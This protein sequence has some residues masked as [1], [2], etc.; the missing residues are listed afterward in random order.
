MHQSTIHSMYQDE[1][2]I[3]WFGTKKGL[4]RYDGTQ[5]KPIQKLFQDIPDA[6]ELVRGITG[7][8]NGK[9]YLETRSG[10]IQYDIRK[11]IFSKIT[12]FSQCMYYTD[13]CLWIGHK[14]V[15]YQ[16]KNQ[17][18]QT[19][20]R[21]PKESSMIDCI[22]ET[23]QG[24][25]YV[26]TREDGVFLIRRNKGITRIMPDIKQIRQLYVDSEQKIWV[27]TRRDGVFLIERN[28]YIRNFSY[29]PDK[30]NCISSNIIRS[31]CEDEAGDVW[32][33][34]F[35]GLNK[36]NR[37]D[38]QFIKYEFI[39]ENIHALNDASIYCLMKDQQGTIWSGSFFGEINCFHPEHGTFAYYFAT[40]KDTSLSS[41][42]HA[43]FGKAVEDKQ[44]NL[45]IA[46][47]RGGLYFFNPQTKQLNK[48]PFADNIQTLFLDKQKDILWIGTLLGGLKQY[49]IK[50][51]ST[52]TYMREALQNNSIREIIPYND[53]LILAT[54]N[55]VSFFTP[56]TKETHPLNTDKIELKG[57][58]ITTIL[59]DSQKQLWIAV[60]GQLICYNLSNKQCRNIYIRKSENCIVNKIIENRN[61]DIIIG[62]SRHGVFKKEKGKNNFKSL[63]TDDSSVKDIIDITEDKHGGIIIISNDG[64]THVAQNHEITHIN[65][66]RF[67]PTFQLS[68]N[69]L[70]IDHEQNIYLGGINM[71]CSFPLEQIFN[72]PHF[73]QVGISDISVN[74]A[75]L[76]VNDLNGLLKESIFYTDRIE[77][78]YDQHT[79][80]IKVFTNSYTS[81]FN[82]CIKYKLEPFDKE[83]KQTNSLNEISYNNLSP[84]KY[85]LHI[86][87]DAALDN[88]E[89]PEKK[90]EIIIKPPF[91]QTSIAYI[92][93][94][95]LSIILLYEAY[96]VIMLRSSLKIE[97][98][99]KENMEKL[100]QSKLRFF[101]NISH[102]FKTPL[103][104]ISNQV[105]L[106][107]QTPNVPPKLQVK[108]QSIWKNIV[109]LNQL[110]IELMEFRKQ[111][112]GFT[113]L[114]VT[115]CNFVDHINE[116]VSS[117]KEYAQ[118][119]N[120]SLNFIAGQENITFYFDKR[121]I[122]KALFNLLSN[123]FKFTPE[124]GSI[125]VRISYEKEKVTLEVID[126]GVGIQTNELDN[127]FIRFYQTDNACFTNSVGTGIGLAYTKN[128]VEAHKGT[129]TVKSVKGKGS[130][131]TIQLP[132]DITYSPKEVQE[133]MP[134]IE[135]IE[136]DREQLISAFLEE[137]KNDFSGEQ[138]EDAES[139]KYRL[140]IVEDNAELCR[141][142]AEV[143]NP[144]Y[145][146]ETA[147]NGQ[148]GYEK[149]LS[150]LPDIIISDVI[151][152]EMTG[153]ELCRKLKNHLETSHIP[154]I[155][156][157]SQTSLEY[158]TEGLQTG[159][160]DYINKPFSIKHLIIRCNNLV[161]SRHMLQQKY[162]KDA[163]L[164]NELVATT[165]LDQAI[166]DKSVQLI[167][168]NLENPVFCVDYLAQEIGIGRTKYFAKIKAITGMTPNDFI[169][170]IKLKLAHQIM[171]KQPDIS[172]SELSMQ[173]GFNSTSYFI[174]RF[175]EFSGMTPNQYKQR[176]E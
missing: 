27:A 29:S 93:Y 31:I 101:T 65:K 63:L 43:V 159:A 22:I 69:C 56:S 77:L 121:L 138:Q 132:T 155:L 118:S 136:A 17:R 111:E 135:N 160:D 128:I 6:E 117:F 147:E 13:S 46:A 32:I 38:N 81:S 1:F 125:L 79:I 85:I 153:T 12:P 100:N 98:E 4:V 21:L 67:L 66:S 172:V 39:S 51:R 96:Q 11:E 23:A 34:T 130:C 52:T 47:E 97:K 120:V 110:I 84:N 113:T 114:K 88:G 83:W 142:L 78:P 168:E 148:C 26:G 104:L 143:F 140:L 119:R 107:L 2:G 15:V 106:L 167:E 8:K 72:K 156:L 141:L 62:T 80:G 64:F 139:K 149:A 49:N 123:A 174:K 76:E 91:Y 68:S 175:K 57:K 127:I 71:F 18:M 173:L 24:N 170:N 20:Y 48:L 145:W 165:P 19:Y 45:W 35:N 3:M 102:E 16:W 73:Y 87:G 171:D 109:R 115:Q 112:Q 103:T 164:S 134:I 33:A 176:R 74:D 54:H 162:A 25:V 122:E 94:I 163:S 152:P 30:D 154:I 131:F 144:L 44:G 53:E 161:K 146:V 58:S 60:Q 99:K 166:L 14:N 105:E 41:T 82:C 108:L 61:G 50:D 7:D 133:D 129:I 92:I 5:V 150:F 116:I 70:Y 40:N 37:S 42:Q 59:L 10:I 55:G 28:E 86:Q 75:L 9:L 89:F 90:L 124:K 137:F 95:L 126:T 151:M 157:T 36:Y 158:V 169:V